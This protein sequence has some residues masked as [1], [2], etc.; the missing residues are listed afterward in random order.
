MKALTN[1]DI[2]KILDDVDVYVQIIKNIFN[3]NVNTIMNVE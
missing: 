3:N 1:M 2:M